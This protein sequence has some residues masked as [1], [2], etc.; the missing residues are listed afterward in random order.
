MVPIAVVGLGCRFPGADDLEAFWRLLSEGR[1]AITDVPPDR[2][3][4]EAFY[5]AKAGVPAKICTR[6]AGFLDGIDLFAASF[7][8]ISA[9]EARAMDPQ[10]RLLLEVAWQA[11]EHGGLAADRLAG[12]AEGGFMGLASVDYLQMSAAEPDH[13]RLIGAYTGTGL[14][15]SIAVNRIS[16][17]LDFRGPSLAVDTA[18]SSSL[19]AVHLACR[20]LAQKEC[21]LAL[22][23]GGNLI[24]SPETSIGFSHAH[25]LAPD[26]RCKTFDRRADGYVRGEGCGVAVL[27]RLDDALV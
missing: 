12:T 2:W 11:L 24:L 25:M 22:A 20:S 5:D 21:N 1:E 14:A 6:R 4:V 19:V 3:D 15:H 7:F 13:Y 9:K 10:Q 27:K 16:Y 26:G 18:C 8:G 23:G 17:L